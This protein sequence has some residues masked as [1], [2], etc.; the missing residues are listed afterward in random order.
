[1]LLNVD[2]RDSFCVPVTFIEQNMVIAE[3]LKLKFIVTKTI[4]IS[5]ENEKGKMSVFN[6]NDREKV[7]YL[8]FTIITLHN[9][10]IWIYV[11]FFLL[12]NTFTHETVVLVQRKKK[13]FVYIYSVRLLQWSLQWN[14]YAHSSIKQQREK[15][16]TNSRNR[17]Y[18]YLH[19][20]VFLS[21][22]ISIWFSLSSYHSMLLFY[23]FF[24]Q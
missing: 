12:L 20:S 10:I 3:D 15:K 1:M 14:G 16:K 13:S 21:F 8:I 2:N 23:G 4:F 18:F 11:L 9:N 6:A 22:F 5:T 7:W 17:L 19:S 24:K